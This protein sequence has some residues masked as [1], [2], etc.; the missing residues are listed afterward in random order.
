MGLD[1]LPQPGRPP[2]ALPRAHG[3]RVHR[4]DPVAADFAEAACGAGRRADRTSRHPGPAARPDGRRYRLHGRPWPRPGQPARVDPVHRRGD[5]PS[6]RVHPARRMPQPAPGDA[7][8]AVADR[9]ADRGRHLLHRHAAARLEGGRSLRRRGQR[10]AGHL[11]FADPRQLR[12]LVPARSRPHRALGRRSAQGRHRTAPVAA[13]LLRRLEA[14][15]ARA[16]AAL[17]RG[18]P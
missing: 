7:A 14:D 11:H 8:G 6:W 5:R 3:L 17:E 15:R 1:F 10:R 13:H 12:D 16:V 18:G 4:P 9:T 2:G